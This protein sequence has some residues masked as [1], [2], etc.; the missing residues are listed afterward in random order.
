MTSALFFK[1]KKPLIK[2]TELLC[3]CHGNRLHFKKIAMKS[4]PRKLKGKSKILLLWRDI[5][6]SLSES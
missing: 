1:I 4:C 6:F 2:K 5:V 3:C